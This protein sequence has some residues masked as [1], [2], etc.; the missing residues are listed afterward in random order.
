MLLEKKKLTKIIVSQNS[1]LID[2][3]N[4]L[5]E[6]TLK[7]VL[8]V[9]K[10]KKFVGIIND[11][12][13]RRGFLKGCNLNSSIKGIINTK[14]FFV[15]TILDINNISQKKLKL[16][17]HIPII[18]NNKIYG[19]YIQNIFKNNNKSKKNKE[20]IVIMAGG[21]GKRL[22]SL[23]KFCPKALL[24]FD[25]KPLLQHILEHIN[26]NNFCNVY[27][28]VFFLKKIIRKFISDNNFFLK[29]KFIEEK[30]PL[31]SIGAIRLIKKISNNF[32]VMNCDVITDLDLSKLLRFHKK[33]KSLLTISTKSYKYTNPYGV[34][35]SRNNKFV[36]FSEK[37]AMNFE[38]NAG[39]Y[40]FN[41]KIINIMN[42]L[43]INN[44]EDLIITL[45]KKNFK[46]LT[47]QVFE[48]WRDLGSDKK[49][50]KKFN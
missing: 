20:H 35:V 37:P 16:F 4:N 9:D 15:K 40:V 42:K 46:I 26:K 50:L 29:V 30:N 24:K 5:N 11:G 47:Y 22:G 48:N 23:T 43:D 18:K 31:G 34:I 7:I 19:L 6:S 38:I 44:I 25:N 45:K 8:V 13:L 33:N 49:N 12:D 2:V 21:Y 1:K 3:I 39:I 28:S 27:L 10:N 17:S 41:K 14:P 36:S 32:I